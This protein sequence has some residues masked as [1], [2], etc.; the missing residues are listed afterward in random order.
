MRGLVNDQASIYA[1]LHFPEAFSWSN[2]ELERKTKQKQKGT[3]A[4][5]SSLQEGRA[6]SGSYAQCGMEPLSLGVKERA[7]SHF[8]FVLF[9]DFICLTE[10]K[11]KHKQGEQEREAGALLSRESDT[12]PDP[13]TLRS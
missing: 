3:K 13:R 12:G 6:A 11:R 4:A 10:R 9:Q 5:G 1:A 2:V 8:G 7:G